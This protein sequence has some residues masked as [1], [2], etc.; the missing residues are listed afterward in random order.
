MLLYKTCR[1]VQK[2]DRVS[3]WH[4]KPKSV[5]LVCLA[6]TSPDAPD[7]PEYN[8][9]IDATEY[10]RSG[11]W[12][13]SQI[14]VGTRIFSIYL[15]R[16]R[17]IISWE[18]PKEQ[19]KK[20]SKIDDFI[21]FYLS[22]LAAD[23]RI[24]LKKCIDADDV[25]WRCMPL[26]VTDLT[27][28]RTNRQQWQSDGVTSFQL[29]LYDSSTQRAGFVRISRHVILCAGIG[30]RLQQDV[31]NLIYEKL[32]YY[33]LIDTERVFAFIDGLSRYVLPSELNIFLQGA[34]ARLTVV[35]S[36]SAIVIA[37]LQIFIAGFNWQGKITALFI[38]IL[39]IVLT[40]FLTRYIRLLEWE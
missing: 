6:I 1:K 8:F 36:V 12:R 19:K 15:Y 11:P 30:P 2:L 31:V 28:D 24:A 4:I 5:N 13:V 23:M 20:L 14:E 18:I 32:L 22:E 7:L 26:L 17:A 3:A 37:I 33:P 38:S 16:K 39:V 29:R 21:R 35:F 10:S 25:T 34:V 27:I 9:H 40:W